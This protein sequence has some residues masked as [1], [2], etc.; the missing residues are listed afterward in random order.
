MFD[1]IPGRRGPRGDRMKDEVQRVYSTLLTRVHRK[2]RTTASDELP[3]LI[4]AMDLPVYKRDRSSIVSMLR[5]CGLHFHAIVL[6]PPVSRLKG[7]LADH[8]RDNH[9]L[10]AGPTKLVERVHV[11]PVTHDHERVVDYVFKTVWNGR[12]THDDAILVLPRAR[13]ELGSAGSTAYSVASKPLGTRSEA[14]LA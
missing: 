2:P 1:Q 4:G 11:V 8:F 5:N 9:L 13:S 14:D 7:S 10:Y 12:L 6:L 3:V